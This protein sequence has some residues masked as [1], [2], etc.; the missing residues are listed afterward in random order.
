MIRV[1]FFVFFRFLG[2]AL[3]VLQ[4]RTSEAGLLRR[5]ARGTYQDD[6]KRTMLFFGAPRPS[7]E[8]AARRTHPESELHVVARFGQVPAPSEYR[9]ATVGSDYGALA[10]G[11]IVLLTKTGSATSAS[12]S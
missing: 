2:L 11:F 1:L 4:Y 7:R 10:L 12:A 9:T 8:T 5:W 3:P 6:F